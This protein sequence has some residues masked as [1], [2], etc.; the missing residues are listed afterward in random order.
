MKTSLIQHVRVI[1][2]RT[3]KERFGTTPKLGQE[4]WRVACH[5]GLSFDESQNTISLS[6]QYGRNSF[7]SS[8]PGRK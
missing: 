7:A 5:P 1:Y 6:G 4:V 8:M 3:Q 2:Q